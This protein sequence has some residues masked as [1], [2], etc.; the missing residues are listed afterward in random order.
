MKTSR[1]DCMPRWKR[2][3][4]HGEPGCRS[5]IKRKSR[6]GDYIAAIILNLIFLWIVNKV[7][8]WKPGFIRDNYMVVL[9]V[10]NVNIFV[11]LGCNL[12]MLLAGVWVVRRLARIIM[13][14]ASFVTTMVLLYIYPFDFSHFHD[15]F[16]VD[17]I[18]PILFIIGMV[19]SAIKVVSNLWRLLFR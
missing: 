3:A 11:Q 8:D 19:V 12:L 10:L 7:P 18:L 14:S 1:N 6:T 15:L 9:W 17:K 4:E 16:W 5:E 13:E 2:W